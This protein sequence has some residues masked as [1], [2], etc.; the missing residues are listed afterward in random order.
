M[1][2]Q[3]FASLGGTL[4]FPTKDRDVYDLLKETCCRH[5]YFVY[6]QDGISY[7][8]RVIVTPH[9]SYAENFVPH[10]RFS[11]EAWDGFCAEF[12]E[13]RK[14]L[15]KAGRIGKQTK[16]N[17][18]ILD[19]KKDDPLEKQIGYAAWQI[20]LSRFY[21]PYAL[22]AEALTDEYKS[23]NLIPD[24]NGH[25]KRSD[26]P[27]SYCTNAAWTFPEGCPYGKTAQQ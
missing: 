25:L 13:D 6:E 9:F 23:G 18:V 3:S 24:R 22:I 20:L 4:T 17:M 10:A 16:N 12:P 21:D 26:G 2:E 27:C 11:Q 7:R 1:F 19:I 14:I 8:A 15:E 5:Q